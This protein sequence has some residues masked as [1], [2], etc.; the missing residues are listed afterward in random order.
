[1]IYQAAE[2]EIF[3]RRKLKEFYSFFVS[4]IPLDDS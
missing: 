4:S 3:F 1:M 2:N